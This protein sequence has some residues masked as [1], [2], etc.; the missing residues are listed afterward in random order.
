MELKQ[1][2]V[3]QAVGETGSFSAA[4]ARLDYTQPAVSK[5][6]AGLER[7]LGTTLVDRGIRPLRLTDAGSALAQRAGAAFEQIAAAEL[8]VDAIANLSGGTLHVGTFSSAGA[9]MVVDALRLFRAGHPDVVVSIAEIGMPSALVRAL[10]SGDLDLGVSF[11][12]PEAGGSSIDEGLELQP[13]LDD[14]FD[15]VVPRGHR[16]EGRPRVRFA[17]LRNEK[18]LLPDFGVD[19]PSF[20]M[21]DRRCRDGGFEPDIGYRINDCQMTQA[22]VAAGEG[23]ALLPRLML[24]AAHPGVAIRPL[25]ADPPVRRVCALRL[26]TRYLTPA[27]ERFMELLVEASARHAQPH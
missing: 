25:A 19:S 14:P 6:V 26:P 21:I 9:A 20:R 16:L 18:W 22:L 24:L 10:R 15:V 11:D 5:I 27:T 1:L 17:E 13:L 7:Q 3:L 12:Y 23:I 8:E 4:A 2:R